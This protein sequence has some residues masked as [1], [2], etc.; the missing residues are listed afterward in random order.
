MSE[1]TPQLSEFAEAAHRVL[2]EIIR[3]MA[4]P[5]QVDI[6]V[7]ETPEQ[8]MLAISSEEPLGVLIGQGG[9]TLNALELLVR[10]M[11]QHKTASH[12]KA[13]TVDAEG[14]RT[15]QVDQMTVVARAAAEEA[16]ATGEPVALD[17]MTPRDRRTVHMVIA[18][19]PGVVSD[20]A[21]EEPNRHIV[22]YPE[23]YER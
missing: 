21:G 11:A 16:I 8:V 2:Q 17:P 18:E 19:I 5:G 10:T 3:E 15:Q 7:T 14:F 20:S 9:Q 23:G 13:I 22:V 6:S 1:S 4:F 12:G